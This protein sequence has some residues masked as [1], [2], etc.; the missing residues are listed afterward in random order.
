MPP[1]FSHWLPRC[2]RETASLLRLTLPI[3]GAQLAQSG[4]SAADVIMSGRA[5]ATDLAAVSV[6]ASLWVPLMLLMTGTLM[7]ITPLVA[8][9]VGAGRHDQVPGKVHQALWV[10]LVFG[11]ASA[12]LLSVGSRAVFT[13]MEI[14]DDVAALALDYLGAVAFGIPAVAFYQALRG[15]SDGMHHT[16]PSLWMSLLGLGFNIPSNYVLIYGGPGLVALFGDSL[17]SALQSLPALG[18]LGCGIATAISMWAMCLGM[19]LYTRRSR[20]YAPVTLWQR[21]T[22]PH[23]REIGELL[24]IGLPIGLAIFF[25]V[26]LFTV[27]TL[28]VAYLGEVTVAAHQIA[29]NVTSILFMLPLSLSMALTVRVSNRLG[30]G[31]PVEARFVAWNGVGIGLLLAI[32]NSLAIWLLAGP[33]VSVYTGND[34]VRSLAL[35]LILLAMLFQISDSLQVNLAGALRGYKDT[36]VVMGITLI[37]YWLVGLGVGHCLGRGLDGLFD[38]LGIY[39]YWIGLNAGLTCAAGLLGW[40]LHVRGERNVRRARQAGTQGTDAAS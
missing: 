40:R 37:S 6:G 21:P 3:C 33:I 25:E 2:R 28:L 24:Y 30:A 38:A 39:G 7:G 13:W 16:R 10:A 20:A 17:P 15:F 34:A 12:L 19:A 26:T 23:W 32:F 35:S 9:R 22:P 29:L 27:I 14:P 31:D 1:S 4:M 11:L 36:R 8:H 5:S 18:A